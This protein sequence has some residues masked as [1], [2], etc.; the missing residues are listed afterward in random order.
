MGSDM[1][2]VD[3]LAAYLRRDAREVGKL[4]SRGRLPGHKVGGEWRFARAEINRWLESQMPGYT[5]EQLTVFEEARGGTA[6]PLLANLLSPACVAVPLAASTKASVLREMV[7]LAE[8][9]WEIYDPEAIFEAVRAREELVS[10]ALPTGVAF[11]HPRRP[12]SA[13]LG[14]SVLAFGRTASGV[15]YGDPNGGLTDCF[16]LICCKDDHTHLRVLARLTRLLLRDGFL[17]EL[18]AGETPAEAYDVITA[19]EQDLLNS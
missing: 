1:M 7:K 15:P 2:D 6:E 13:A 4:A 5:D 14:E 18:R 8:E 17:A 11:P 12:L 3:Q 9:S 16:F 19:A 10:T